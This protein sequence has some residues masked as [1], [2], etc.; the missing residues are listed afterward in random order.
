MSGA[1]EGSGNVFRI[2]REV[3]GLSLRDVSREAGVSAS[4]LSRIETGRA[5]PS[6]RIVARLCHFYGTTTARKASA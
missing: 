6:S 4:H 3:L 5:R 1:N 2:F